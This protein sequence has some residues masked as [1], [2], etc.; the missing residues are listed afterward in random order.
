MAA[1]S[2]RHASGRCDGFRRGSFGLLLAST[3]LIGACSP[4]PEASTPGTVRPE[5]MRGATSGLHFWRQDGSHRQSLEFRVREDGRAD[6]AIT[7]DGACTRSAT[8]VADPAPA[9]GDVDV[10]VDPDGEG[11]PV[12]AFILAPTS[13]CRIEIRLAAP[14]RE[15]A[16]LHE[17]DCADS[18]PLSDEP[19]SRR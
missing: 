2:A 18:C 16:W 6:V 12:D 8:G 1:I 17:W 7:V 5:L 3:M 10:E 9:E 4:A 19:M 11:H 13:D 15:Y 14:D